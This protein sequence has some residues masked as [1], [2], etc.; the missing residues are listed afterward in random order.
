MLLYRLLFTLFFSD[1]WIK[2]TLY[3][4]SGSLLFSTFFIEALS[5]LTMAKAKLVLK[6]WI[7]IIFYSRV[8][9]MISL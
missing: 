4:N 5:K 1:S 7:P 2:L 9:F 8:S 3:S 6:R